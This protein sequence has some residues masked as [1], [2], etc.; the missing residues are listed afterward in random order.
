MTMIP[1]SVI[2]VI[3]YM[4]G[5]ILAEFCSI[6]LTL[7]LI[8]I[9][10]LIWLVFERREPLLL[11]G[12]TVLGMF[13]A[14]QTQPTSDPVRFDMRQS[15]VRI[16]GREEPSLLQ[17]VLDFSSSARLYCRTRLER[18]QLKASTSGLAQSLLFG[19]KDQVSRETKRLMRKAGMSHIMAVSGLHVGVIWMVLGWLLAPIK[20]LPDRF[21]GESICRVILFFAL[22]CYIV[23]TGCP[24]SAVRAGI[25][26]S[27]VTLSW[28]W[29]GDPTGWHNLA[30]AA[31]LILFYDPQLF[32]NIGFQLSFLA[33]IGIYSFMPIIGDYQRPF[34]ERWFWLSISAQL[35]TLPVTAYYFH[36]VPFFGWLQGLLVVPMLPFYLPIL[37]LGIGIP[38]AWLIDGERLTWLGEGLRWLIEGGEWWIMRVAGWAIDLE[39]LCLGEHLEVYPSLLESFLMGAAICLGVGAWRLSLLKDEKYIC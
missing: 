1:Q 14:Y 21:N 24:P 27:L 16:A 33:M 37:A 2:L 36:S 32:W 23:L 39:M 11:L 10:G 22:W 34:W 13:M 5:I 26:I 20:L 7:W 38:S 6:W 35:F 19:S 15:S 18:I 29:H 3:A 28:F 8:G 17:S 30:I 9:G 12:M 31:Q 4:L 25:M